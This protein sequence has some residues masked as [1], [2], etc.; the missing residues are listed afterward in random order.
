M[1]SYEVAWKGS[2]RRELRKLP[3]RIIQKVVAK[4]EEL[5]DDPLPRD[6]LKLKGAD[7]AY[8]VRLG[9]YRI[10]YSLHK[11]ELII[12]VLRVGHRKEVYR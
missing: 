1:A 6:A 4:V 10:V 3:N 9:N 5:A 11:R 12:E 7:H 2:A 8:R